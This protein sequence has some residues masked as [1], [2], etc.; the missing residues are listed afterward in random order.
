LS[1]TTPNYGLI[2]P[3]L[4]DPANIT[5]MNENWDKIDELLGTV[6]PKMTKV[7]ISSSSWNTNTLTQTVTVNGILADDTLQLVQ[8]V[9]SPSS[10]GV[11]TESGAYCSGQGTNTLTFTCSTIPSEDIVFNVSYQNATYVG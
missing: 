6:I 3:E 11:A 5:V 2:K 4:T 9:P 7:T 10:M 1:T 8:A